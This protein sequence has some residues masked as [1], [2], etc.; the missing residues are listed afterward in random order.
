METEQDIFDL[1]IIGGGINGAGIACDAAGRGL[2]VALCEQGD[3]GAATSSASSKLIHGGLRYLEHYEFRLVRESLRERDVLLAKAPHLVGRREFVLPHYNSSR[4]AWMVRLGLFLYDF[5]AQ[6]SRLASTRT[7]DL[8]SDSMGAPLKEGIR[9]GFVYSDCWVDDSRLVIVN[10]M[11]AA[12]AGARIETRTRLEH[13][14]RNAGVWHA[15]INDLRTGGET[16]WRARAMVNATGPWAEDVLEAKIDNGGKAKYKIRLVKGSHLVVPRL[17][18]AEHAYILQNPDGRV[19]F[20]LPFQDNYSLLGTTE[21]AFGGDPD[22][23]SMD[24]DEAR[25]ICDS[26]NAYWGNPVSPDDAIWSFAGVRPL[27]DDDAGD[28]SA[29]SREYVLDLQDADG[30][31]PLLSIFGGKLTTYRRLAEQVLTRLKPFFPD[32][33]KA[34]TQ[35][36]PLPGGDMKGGDFEEFSSTLGND[37]PALDQPWLHDLARR[38]G[39]RA[40]DILRPGETPDGLGRNFGAGLFQ[41][42]IEYLVEREWA[43]TADD[44][45]WRRT[46]CGL[47]MT[48]EERLAVGDYMDSIKSLKRSG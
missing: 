29:T 14:E 20:V 13:A 1:L 12:E 24:A 31:A 4:P 44:V 18:D 32:M 16:V 17:Y 43:E 36:G 2:K 9:K 37:Y 25:Y 6:S 15:T 22:E 42:E 7:V 3:L 35:T 19:V 45:L 5:L 40:R 34:W 41:R 38:H 10:I 26:V 8:G 11:A 27:F 30:Q 33:G 28:P 46:K 21:I 47:A 48:D 39:T 23:A